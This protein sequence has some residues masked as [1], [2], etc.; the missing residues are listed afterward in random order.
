M[1][2][3]DELAVDVDRERQVGER[4]TLEELLHA[5]HHIIAMVDVGHYFVRSYTGDLLVYFN[6]EIQKR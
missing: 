4:F 5:V 2:I 1:H 3:E 6:L